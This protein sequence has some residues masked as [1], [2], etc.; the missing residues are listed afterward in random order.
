MFMAEMVEPCAEL[1]ERLRDDSDQL[2][3]GSLRAAK[4]DYLVTGDKDLLALAKLYPI[5][6]PAAFW[7]RHGE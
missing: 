6:T 4:A 3:L 2:V 5:V 1:D 7:A